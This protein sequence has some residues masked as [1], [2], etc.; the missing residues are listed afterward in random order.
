MS[1]RF[2][3]GANSGEGFQSLY[4]QILDLHETHDFL[5]LKGGPGAGKSTFMKRIAQAAEQANSP[6]EY[7]YCSGDP[8]SLDAVLL[9]ECHTAVADGTSPHGRATEGHFYTLA[10]HIKVRLQQ[11]FSHAVNAPNTAAGGV[12]LVTPP[13]LPQWIAMEEWES[14]NQRLFATLRRCILTDK[15][16]LAAKAAT[17]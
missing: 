4:P 3:L 13:F 12:T 17:G 9:P 1:I 6:V 14:E 11:Q 10:Y 2:F 8:D 16:N 7:I 5:I 15:G